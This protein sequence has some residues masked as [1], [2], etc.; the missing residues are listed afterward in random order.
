MLD[1]KIKLP[2]EQIQD[3]LDNC[4]AHLSAKE[5]ETEQAI[6]SLLK[7]ARSIS[8]E[9]YEIFMDVS[10]Q[11]GNDVGCIMPVVKEK[12]T[13]SG[14]ITLEIRWIKSV[15]GATGRI[16]NHINKGVGHSYSLGKLTNKRPEWEKNL[17]EQT[18]KQFS[19][20]R[21]L[22]SLLIKA[23]SNSRSIERLIDKK[24]EEFDH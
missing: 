15:K 17:I 11:N 14:L 10:G 24:N 20:I 18:E 3:A 6:R 22:Y 9:Y 13:T 8:E 16:R 5:S 7:S 12:V 19:T 21:E 23:R 2:V 4:R 1:E